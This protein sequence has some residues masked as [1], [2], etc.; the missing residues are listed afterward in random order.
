VVTIH[1]LWLERHPEYSQKFFGQAGSSRRSR[2]TAQKAR[3][4]IT[5][6]S[7]SAGE[8]SALYGVRPERIRV[9]PNGVSEEFVPVR[10][11]V[12]FRALRQRLGLGAVPYVLFVG[13]ADPRKNH[14]A[15]LEA[16]A[17]RPK[18]LGRFTLVLAGDATHQ[19]GN[20]LDTAR[21]LGI[22]GQVVCTGRLPIGDIRLL[23]SHAEVFVYPSLYEGFGMPALEAMACGAPVVTSNTTA[24]GE[25][26]GDAALSVDPHDAAA[27]ADGILRLS[28]DGALRETM[29]QRGFERVKLFTW[30]RAAALTLS[31][32]RELCA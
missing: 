7:F 18:E 15:L 30:R 31:L 17:Q 6:S 1:D 5:V 13:G 10:D 8:I 25:V 26:A 29:T 24:L 16:V 14:R 28:E 20:Y 11:E 3:A 27:L 19:Y 12:A 2:R 21:R 32:Y 9:I 22:E 4:I 23:Y